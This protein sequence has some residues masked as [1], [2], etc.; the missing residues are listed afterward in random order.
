MYKGIYRWIGVKK[1]AEFL[2]RLNG[3]NVKRES[4]VRIPEYA[5]ALEAWKETEQEWEVFLE[6]LPAGTVSY[7][8]SERK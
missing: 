8:A 6:T 7:G 1:V 4:Y 2:V 3:E 5:A